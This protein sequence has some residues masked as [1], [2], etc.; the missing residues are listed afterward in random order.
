M[1]TMAKKVGIDYFS[2]P[3]Y[4]VYIVKRYISENVFFLKHFKD[5][6][7]NLLT[8]FLCQLTKVYMRSLKTQ[9]CP[10]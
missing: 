2:V 7:R 1:V 5:P 4:I 8:T 10:S 3:E 6:R 9:P